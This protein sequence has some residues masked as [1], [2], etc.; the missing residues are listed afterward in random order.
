VA[1]AGE[2][3]AGEL[4][5]EADPDVRIGLVVPQPDVEL[6]PVALDELLLG[7]QR[8]GLGLGDQEVDRGDPVD[9][10]APAARRLAGEMPG[11]PLADRDRLADVED[12]PALVLEQV[13]ARLIGQFPSLLVQGL[14]HRAKG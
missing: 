9:H 8:F 2:V 4:L 7:E 13:H 10:L 1:L 6:R 12:P 3:D 5:V 11:H 14:G